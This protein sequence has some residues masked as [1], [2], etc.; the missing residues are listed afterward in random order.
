MIALDELAVQSQLFTLVF[1]VKTCSQ[2]LS[3]SVCCD[4]NNTVLQIKRARRFFSADSLSIVPGQL[5]VHLMGDTMEPTQ[6][7]I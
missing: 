1:T 5:H 6:T 7:E 3:P 4:L 2:P